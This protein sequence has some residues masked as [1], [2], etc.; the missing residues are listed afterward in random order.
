M[1]LFFLAN[2]QLYPPPPFSTELILKYLTPSLAGESVQWLGA[3]IALPEERVQ[4][5]APME[6]RTFTNLLSCARSQARPVVNCL[7]IMYEALGHTPSTTSKCSLRGFLRY[8]EYDLRSFLSPL[9][10]WVERAGEAGKG[11]SVP[12]LVQG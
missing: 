12:H 11:L 9:S 8:R 5:P 7:S 6:I 1:Y 10:L 4:F 2:L 3:C